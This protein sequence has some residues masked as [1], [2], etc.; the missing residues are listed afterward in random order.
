MSPESVAVEGE[1]P[2]R[3]RFGSCSVNANLSKLIEVKWLGHHLLVGT[4]RA[5]GYREIIV[6]D[7]LTYCRIPREYIV[8]SSLSPSTFNQGACLHRPS[9]DYFQGFE[10]SRGVVSQE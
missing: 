6:N 10:P 9:R 2:K 5:N 7:I 3:S 1:V 4:N 8:G